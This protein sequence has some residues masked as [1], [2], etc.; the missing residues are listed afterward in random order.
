MAATTPRIIVPPPFA[1][2]EDSSH[3]QTPTRDSFGGMHGQRPLP[4][5][6]GLGEVARS[7]TSYIGRSDSGHSSKTGESYDVDME[8]ARPDQAS[9]NES[10]TGD[11]NKSASKKKKSQRFFCTDF[12]PCQLSFTRSEHLARHIRYVTYRIGK[13]NALNDY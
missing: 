10:E 6:P 8:D 7:A 3:M 12:P 2:M 9:D 13:E 1:T 5:A 4:S 11:P